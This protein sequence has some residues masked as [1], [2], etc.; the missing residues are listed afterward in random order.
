MLKFSN[1]IVVLFVFF[2]CLNAQAQADAKT[3][4]QDIKTEMK[5][6]W[7]KNR[8]INLVFH[9]HSVPAGYFKTPFINTLDSYP[10]LLLKNLKKEYPNALINIIVTARGGENSESGGKRF[11]T[12][13]LT[14]KPDVVFIDYVLNDRGLGLIRSKMAMRSMI[15][16][17]LETNCKVIL[18]TPSPHQNFDLKDS[19][20]YL[21]AFSTQI[22]ELAGEFQ[23]GCADSYGVFKRTVLSDKISLQNLMSQVN[24]P[25][26]AGH[27]LIADELIKWF[28]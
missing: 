8:T 16:Q 22:K 1:F 23:V 25:N 3:Y 4:L 20:S 14:H 9:G 24:H 27:Q 28:M 5:K 11:K 10:Y 13:V 6:E 7:P 26:K 12:D 19:S 18:L 21:E 17:A 15:Q 2:S